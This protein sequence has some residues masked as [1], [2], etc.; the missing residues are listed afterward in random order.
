M[1]NYQRVKDS[2]FIFCYWT[3]SCL[4]VKP[5]SCTATVCPVYLNRLDRNRSCQF[6]SQ[7]TA[8]R[9]ASCPGQFTNKLKTCY[10]S[11]LFSLLC[12]SVRSRFMRSQSS[13]TVP[14][15]GKKGTWC[16]SVTFQVVALCSQ[17]SSHVCKNVRRHLRFSSSESEWWLFSFR[18]KEK[19]AGSRADGE[20]LCWYSHEAPSWL[21][22]GCLCR[23][24]HEKESSSINSALTVQ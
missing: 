22:S 17:C 8:C 4:Q 10:T 9:T 19:V 14:L 24:S 13:E 23:P 5:L 1:W 7:L 16:K 21:R 3:E 15:T 6:P 18:E 20:R 11:E 2:S 12:C